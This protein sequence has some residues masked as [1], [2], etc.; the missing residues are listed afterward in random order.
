M[1]EEEY[2][3]TISIVLQRL[4]DASPRY[5]D[6]YYILGEIT[7][8]DDT[9]PKN[10]VEHLSERICNKLDHENIALNDNGGFQ[11]KISQLG[12]DIIESGGYL[13]YLDTLKK[14]ALYNAK[15][16]QATDKKLFIELTVANWKKNTFWLW[17]CGAIIGGLFG[18]ISLVL[19]L[20]SRGYIK[21]PL[22]LR[23]NQS[24]KNVILSDSSNKTIEPVKVQTY[25]EIRTK[26]DTLE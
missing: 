11:L 17:F 25:G 14:Q 3:K 5:V 26:T 6:I 13:A 18:V 19:E 7:D 23:Q 12:I 8:L 22:P 2:L 21:V 10:E 4:F 9:P 1:T 16:Q 20:D 15:I 24:V